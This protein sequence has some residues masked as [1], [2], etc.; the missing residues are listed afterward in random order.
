[1]VHEWMG[2]SDSLRRPV[3]S[4]ASLHFSSSSTFTPS[5]GRERTVGNS[6]GVGLGGHFLDCKQSRCFLGHGKVVLKPER[7][8]EGRGRCEELRGS[9]HIHHTVRPGIPVLSQTRSQ[10][11][12]RRHVAS[13][14]P[15]PPPPHPLSPLILSAPLPRPARLS[16]ARRA[17]HLAIQARVKERRGRAAASESTREHPGRDGRAAGQ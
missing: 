12:L 6:R 4:R 7:G 11:P 3:P 15:T 1:M 2:A 14:T 5:L 10:S 8:E 13:A 9:R 16:G 17:A